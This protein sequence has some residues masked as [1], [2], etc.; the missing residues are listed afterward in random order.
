VTARALLLDVGVL[1]PPRYPRMIEYARSID[2]DPGALLTVLLGVRPYDPDTLPAPLPDPESARRRCD[3]GEAT[4]AQA[5]EEIA[6]DFPRLCGKPWDAAGYGRFLASGPGLAVR[7]DAAR[8]VRDAAR[9]GCDV[10]V[11]ATGPAE[12]AAGMPVLVPDGARLVF[13]HELG[14]ARP[15][16]AIWAAS[17]DAAGIATGPESW[18]IVADTWESVDAL[19]GTVSGQPGGTAYWDATANDSWVADV[20]DRLGLPACQ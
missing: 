11:I 13:T 12:F 1:L 10:V 15:D 4:W 6:A 7:L 16:P 5:L 9:S 3:R 20:R 17:A 2:V 18:C 19:R 14:V 8:V